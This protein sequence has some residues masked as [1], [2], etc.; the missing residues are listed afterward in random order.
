MMISKT[1]IAIRIYYGGVTAVC[2]MA[3]LLFSDGV[4]EK[5]EWCNVKERARLMKFITGYTMVY[6]DRPKM[7]WLDFCERYGAN[8]R[9]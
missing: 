4:I 8:V 2:P 3:E 5:I 6:D 1:V 9:N 7:D